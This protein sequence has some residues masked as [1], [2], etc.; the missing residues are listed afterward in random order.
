MGN[1]GFPHAGMMGW[2]S[3]WQWL[4]SFHGVLLLVS[5]VV[6]VVVGF[7]LIRDWRRERANGPDLSAPER[8]Q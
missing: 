1:D 5:L 8:K 4:A 2:D 6:I 3:G 7:A